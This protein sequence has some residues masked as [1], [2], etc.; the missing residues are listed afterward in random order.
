MNDSQKREELIERIINASESEQIYFGQNLT[1]SELNQLLLLAQD[2]PNFR[3]IL[4]IV[5]QFT[6]W[7]DQAFV[8]FFDIKNQYL[9]PY[10]PFL[11][12]NRFINKLKIL[13]LCCQYGQ[14]DAIQ[15][16]IR[17]MNSDS[18]FRINLNNTYKGIT[19]LYMACESGHLAIVKI[20]VQQEQVDINQAK[21]DGT[22]PLSIAC[23][24]N[25]IAIV[26]YLL[27]QPS[28]DVNKQSTSNISPLYIT[29]QN[30]R[31][32]IL[33]LLLEHP[34]INVNEPSPQGITGL[35]I[36][37]QKNHV[38]IVERLLQY[39]KI[40]V[41]Q[42]NPQGAT[43]L[44]IACQQGSFEIIQM[45]LN[46]PAIQ[47]CIYLEYAEI[48]ELQYGLSW[49]GYNNPHTKALDLFFS[50]FNE[51]KNNPQSIRA[52]LNPNTSISSERPPE[53]TAEDVDEFIL[54]NVLQALKQSIEIYSLLTIE[55]TNTENILTLRSWTKYIEYLMI[56]LINHDTTRT[57][58]Q[59]HDDQGQGILH[60]FAQC[61]MLLEL[62]WKKY[63]FTSFNWDIVD[64]DGNTPLL[65]MIKGSDS[66]KTK[67]IIAKTIPVIKNIL[68]LMDPAVIFEANTN[69]QTVYNISSQL[70]PQ[71]RQLFAQIK[72]PQPKAKTKVIPP[73]KPIHEQK[74]SPKEPTSAK[75]H[76]KA[77]PSP[78]HSP[79]SPSTQQVTSHPTHSTVGLSPLPVNELQEI[80]RDINLEISSSYLTPHSKLFGLNMVMIDFYHIMKISFNFIDFHQR[81][82]LF[83][84][85]HFKPFWDIFL[86]QNNSHQWIVGELN[87]N[88][89]NNFYTGLFKNQTSQKAFL[90]NIF[91]LILP[92]GA[93]LKDQTDAFCNKIIKSML[94]HSIDE[95]LLAKKIKKIY[96][97]FKI[98][99]TKQDIY[100]VAI[101]EQ[102]KAITDIWTITTMYPIPFSE[103]QKIKSQ[104][105]EK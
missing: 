84:G 55:R 49:C 25:H 53:Y 66:W 36:A 23:E 57:I 100:F 44:T 4:P 74:P 2:H 103:I 13:L 97:T 60:Y 65:L 73:V 70:P 16:I 9:H 61:P 38:A 89:N 79:R 101:A 40:K 6:E 15:E 41:N 95:E 50:K 37:C 86:N 26:Q 5:C 28:I 69:N 58:S 83:K 8:I 75:S 77:I 91:P 21:P 14:I 78:A 34:D 56:F 96:A 94:V 20:L 18:S 51:M 30:N 47:L 11:F 87:K 82:L 99:H 63:N 46:H 35:F 52:I 72:K 104:S 12:K 92:E 59:Y 68:A 85:G 48:K 80:I 29:C 76:K 10:I 98:D 19:P 39:E 3:R 54:K 27:R 42:P 102:N 88:P 67:E 24:L 81:E 105:T 32:E 31:L 17:L 33:N 90:K 22:T 1:G 62:Y 45:L 71:I 43:P 93:T 7:S 64:N